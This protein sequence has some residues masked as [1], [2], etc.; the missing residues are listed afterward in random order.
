MRKNGMIGLNKAPAATNTIRNP[1]WLKKKS[2]RQRS[3][4]E[5]GN[6]QNRKYDFCY[7]PKS[8]RRRSPQRKCIVATTLAQDGIISKSIMIKYGIFLL[9]VGGYHATFKI[10]SP[11]GIR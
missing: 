5:I 10:K 1:V 9:Y 8:M 2:V 3:G 11:K 7:K 4:Q 6:A